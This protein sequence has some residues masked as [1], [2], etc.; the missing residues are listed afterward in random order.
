MT[1]RNGLRLVKDSLN[2]PLY[3]QEDL[4]LAPIF[5]VESRTVSVEHDGRFE[6]RLNSTCSSFV[7]VFYSLFRTPPTSAVVS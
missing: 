3:C 6:R 2:V 1:L 5:S 7:T 4:R